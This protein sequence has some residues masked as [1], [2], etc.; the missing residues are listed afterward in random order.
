[1]MVMFIFNGLSEIKPEQKQFF[2]YSNLYSIMKMK[3]NVKHTESSKIQFDLF[4]SM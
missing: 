3:F 1:M 2:N 4:L